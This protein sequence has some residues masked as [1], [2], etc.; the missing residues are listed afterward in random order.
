MVDPKKTNKLGSKDGVNKLHYSKS[1]GNSGVVLSSGVF[2]GTI[3][4][5]EFTIEI[6]SNNL[7]HHQTY[8]KKQQVI[9]QLVTYLHTNE[10]LGYRKISSKM[11][12][13]GIP[14]QRGN[15]WLPQSVHSILKRKN[16]RDT[17][18]E[19]LRNRQYPI[20]MSKMSLKYHT[21]D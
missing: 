21:F 14:T 15:K 3:P 16:Q 11:N 12:Q 2:Q 4:H 9:H 10:G 7:T 8:S 5:L 13:W 19:E 18:V 6:Q 17:R 1:S 20:K